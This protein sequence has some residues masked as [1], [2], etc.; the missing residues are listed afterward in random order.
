MCFLRKKL[1]TFQQFLIVYKVMVN[2]SLSSR[3]SLVRIRIDHGI[4]FENA[5]FDELYSTNGIK[6]DFS[7]PI[8]LQQN[9]VVEKKNHV[10][11]KL[12][13]VMLNNKNLAKHFWAEA[14]SIVCYI[15]NR[16]FLRPRT[17][18]TPYEL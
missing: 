12:T 17:D 18:V 1:D 13:R 14:M 6:H 8:T 15:S 9:G 2:E 11:I 3:P 4:K 7:A 5:Q 16:V 10:L